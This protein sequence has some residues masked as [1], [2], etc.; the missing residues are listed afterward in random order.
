MSTP[1]P[2]MEED[3]TA[4]GRQEVGSH[5]P[6]CDITTVVKVAHI[7]NEAG[8]MEPCEI[9]HLLVPMYVAIKGRYPK[10]W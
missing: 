2:L 4:P 1:E 5:D 10:D 9:C 8:T 3:T 6:T 7:N